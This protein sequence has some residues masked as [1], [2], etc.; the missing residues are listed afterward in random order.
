MLAAG[1][2][3]YADKESRVFLG[4]KLYFLGLADQSQFDLTR[5]C[6]SYRDELTETTRERV[7]SRAIIAFEASRAK[8]RAVL[9]RSDLQTR[10]D[11]SS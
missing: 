6:R 11:V 8:M 10:A 4:R 7:A 9:A 5:E 1:I 2:L 3:E